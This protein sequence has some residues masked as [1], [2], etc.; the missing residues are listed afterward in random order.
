V[1]GSASLVIG[2]GNEDGTAGVGSEG[3]NGYEGVPDWV[4]EGQEPSASLRREEAGGGTYVPAAQRAEMLSASERLDA[5]V[6][7]MRGDEGIG[8][9]RGK[10]VGK[11][12]T[13][14]D[15]LAEDEKPTGND[16]NAEEEGS[17]EEETDEETDEESDEDETDEES[18]EEEEDSD[19]DEESEEEEEDERA[20][21]MK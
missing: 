14:D 11:E 21:L 16:G 2:S 1:L 9:A 15:W 4:K 18:D 8:I 19:E 7:M 5:Q 6:G 17:S 13:L 12:K 10:K 20:T 3:F